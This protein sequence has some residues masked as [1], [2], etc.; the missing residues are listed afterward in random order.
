M[1]SDS[2]LILP[3][4][5]GTDLMLGEFKRLCCSVR[6]TRVGILPNDDSLDY[7]GLTDYFSSMV[8][9][10]P[11]CHIVAESFSGPIGILIARRYPS[12]V[13]RLTLVASF[14]TSPVPRSASLLPW[15]LL[16]KFPMP[17]LAARY[18]LV[19]NCIQ[20]VPTLRSAIRQ[21]TSAILRHRLKLVQN[22]NV[23][24]EL[25]ELDCSISYIRPLH[26]RLV[27]RSCVGRMIDANPAISVHE[28]AGPHLI[29][30]TQ[31]ENSWRYIAGANGLNERFI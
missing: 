13:S 31:P 8:R 26:D 16:F 28:I 10:L 14:A 15:S 30:E 25:S 21:N 6:P 1:P 29:L 22:V 20:L 23:T 27:P 2:I 24:Q 12:I 4:L 9:D 19:G 18:L 5:D 3:G 7:I 11:D 17:S